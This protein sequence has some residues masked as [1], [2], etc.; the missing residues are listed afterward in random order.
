MKKYLVFMFAAMLTVSLSVSAQNRQGRQGNF[1]RDRQSMQ[2]TAKD[3]VEW[4][5]K[6]VDL[7]DAQKAEVEELFK[8]QDAKRAEDMAKMR[9]S[10]EQSVA[11]RDKMREEMREMRTK[12]MEKNQAELEKIIG[13]E[14]ADKI[15]KIAGYLLFENISFSFVFVMKIERQHIILNCRTVCQPEDRILSVSFSAVSI[16]TTTTT[17][18]ITPMG[19]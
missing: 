6:E 5:A 16:I 3:R 11:N 15:K 2:M 18:T 10:R 14:K 19:V 7:T 9:E 17:T 4:I 13:K 8:K 12:E 1:N